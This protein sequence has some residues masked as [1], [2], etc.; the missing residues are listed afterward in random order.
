MTFEVK[1]PLGIVFRDNRDAH[2]VVVGSINP[3]GL[4]SSYDCLC[5]GLILRACVR[6][7]PSRPPR[8]PSSP[9]PGRPA[10]RRRRCL[11]PQARAELCGA[12]TLFVFAAVPSVGG[13][14]GMMSPG[15]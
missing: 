7:A 13:S 12:S 11:P 9:A 6:A 1:G 14:V 3:D 10:A 8:L 4:A 15:A 2:C 5:E